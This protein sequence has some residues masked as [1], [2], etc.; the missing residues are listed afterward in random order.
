MFD[1]AI[2]LITR[3]PRIVVIQGENPDGDSA[4]SALALEEI[5]GDLGKHVSLYCQIDLPKYLHY[6][7][8]W[9]RITNEFDTK[10]DLAIIVDTSADV[11]IS[12]ALGTPGVRHFLETDPV[13]VIDHHLTEPTLSFKHTLLAEDAV[14]TSHVI[15]NLSQAAEWTINPQ[16]A[17]DMMIALMSDSL[18][19]TTQDHRESTPRIYEKVTGHPSLQ[20]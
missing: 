2:S 4:G 12:K 19:L 15:Y 17:E 6:I 20:G 14:S 9:D 13:I 3:A 1:T 7:N 11:L 18:G 5:L 16:A 8:G 10:A